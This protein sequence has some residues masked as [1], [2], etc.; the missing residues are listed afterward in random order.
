MLV[1]VS[2]LDFKGL[3]LGRGGLGLGLGWWGRDSITATNTYI[4]IGPSMLHPELDPTLTP[5]LF[6]CQDSST[7]REGFVKKAMNMHK[8]SL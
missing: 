1:L 3:G 8:K 7:I 5:W 6:L 4:G 2:V